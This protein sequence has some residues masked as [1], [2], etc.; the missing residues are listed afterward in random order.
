M[1]RD[2]S[3]GGKDLC[4]CGSGKKF[5]QCCYDRQV[6]GQP[7]PGAREV[8]GELGKLVEGRSFGSLEELQTFTDRFMRQRNQA[9]LD[10][11]HGLS[12][13]QMHRIL[14]FP[15]DSPELVTYAPVVAGDPKAPILTL[16][17]LLAEAIGE[18]GLKPTATGNLPRNVCREAA[19]VYWGDEAIRENGRIAHI[20]KEEDFFDLHVTRLVAGLSGLIRK[21]RGRFILSRECRTL[22]SDHG[23][24]GIYPRLLHSYVRDFNWA[25]RDGYTDLG[26]I[27]RSFLFTLY[28]LNRHGG[29]WLPEVFYEDAFLRAFPRV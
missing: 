10:D 28:L 6:S 20:S 3:A 26:F 25:Y 16:F 23:L 24:A 2:P 22:L 9:S 21:S 4:P 18:M 17:G 1:I 14:I 7:P 12:P 11:F 29:E 8:L 13:E 19:S 5:K 15:F 27:Q